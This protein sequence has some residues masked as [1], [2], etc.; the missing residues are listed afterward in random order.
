MEGC[1]EWEGRKTRSQSISRIA[2]KD[3]EPD[4]FSKNLAL[5]FH[6]IEIFFLRKNIRKYV[7]LN[8]ENSCKLIIKNFSSYKILNF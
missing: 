1:W 3:V 7:P 5:M 8:F 4:N 6:S 2:A